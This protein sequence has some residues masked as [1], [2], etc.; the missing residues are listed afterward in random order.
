MG[1]FEHADRLFGLSYD[2]LL[3]GDGKRIAMRSGFRIWTN[4]YACFLTVVYGFRYAKKARK[5]SI[6][7]KMVYLRARGE[8]SVETSNLIVKCWKFVTSSF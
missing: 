6:Y 1:T 5:W 2:Q 7:S 8:S 4:T 3:A